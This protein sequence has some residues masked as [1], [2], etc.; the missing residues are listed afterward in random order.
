M[1]YSHKFNYSDASYPLY[2]GSRSR[3][4]FFVQCSWVYQTTL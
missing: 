3:F 4:W 2:R 1:H